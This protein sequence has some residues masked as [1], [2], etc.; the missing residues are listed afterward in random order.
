MQRIKGAYQKDDA[1][2]DGFMVA[3]F[4]SHQSATPSVLRLREKGLILAAAGWCRVAQK[5]HAGKPCLA[6][7]AEEVINQR[8]GRDIFSFLEGQYAA[9]WVNTEQRQMVAWV[10]RLGLLPAYFCSADGIAWFSTS[11]IVLASV[12]KPPLDL[13]SVRTL[14]LGASP[15]SPH[16]LFEGVSR[17]GCGQHVEL[18]DGRCRVETTWTPYLQQAHYRDIGEAIDEGVERIQACCEGIRSDYR[19]PIMDLTSGLDS[20]LVVAG[21]HKA[22]GENLCVTVS[23]PPDNIDVR[24]A[25]RAAKQFG[26]KILSFPPAR[27]WGSQRWPLFKEGVGLSEGELTGNRIDEVLRVK[28][29]IREAEGVA[30]TGGGGELYRG[31]LW[32]QEFFRI[33]RTSKLNI[34]RLIKYRFDYGA[35]Y[36]SSLFNVEWYEDFITSEVARIEKIVDIAPDALNTAKLDAIFIWKTGGHVGRYAGAAMPVVLTLSPLVTQQ[37]TEY[38]IGVPWRFRA[39]GALVRGLISRLSPELAKLPTWYGSSAEPLTVRRPLELV[40]HGYAAAQ[41]LTRKISHVATGRRLFRDPAATKY[42]P[43]PDVELTRVMLEEGFLSP[44]KLV[45]ARLYNPEGLARFLKRAGQRGFGQ[46]R[47]LQVLVSVELLCRMT[48]TRPAGGSST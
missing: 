2:A 31:S 23:G 48:R 4:P 36:E 30:V 40:K 10:D 26:W 24:I 7:L 35:S 17:L 46:H 37:L 28:K 8:S 39:Q 29:S 1:E 18:R 32:R 12:V 42:D 33:G 21:M 27:N 20:R 16:S 25:K 43:A 34:R 9:V 19:R 47:Q 13:H 44:D 15:K 5:R 38:A 22:E 11:A 6:L 45:S 41:A 14:F 3:R